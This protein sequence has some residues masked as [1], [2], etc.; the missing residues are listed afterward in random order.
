MD[1]QRRLGYYQEAQRILMM[2]LPLV[3]LWHEDNI[4]VT[5]KR[6]TGYG[7]LPINR[8]SPVLSLVKEP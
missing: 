2:Q 3:P 4:V 1:R 6:W 5:G 8:Y 7:L